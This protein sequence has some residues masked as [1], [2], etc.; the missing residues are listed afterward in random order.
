MKR[1]GT[2][3]WR[4]IVVDDEPLARQRYGAALGG[5]GL[6]TH[7]KHFRRIDGHENL[8]A[9]AAILG[10]ETISKNRSR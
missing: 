1:S 8:W 10:R 3:P 4:A 9:V 7:G 6:A 2:S 5:I